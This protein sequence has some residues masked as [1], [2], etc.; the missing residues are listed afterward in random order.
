MPST[1]KPVRPPA[2]KTPDKG[3]GSGNYG[4]ELDLSLMKNQLEAAKRAEA[5]AN[6]AY[7]DLL[8][9]H[10]ESQRQLKDVNKRIIEAQMAQK[11]LD[12]SPAEEFSK[13]QRKTLRSM[14]LGMSNRQSFGFAGLTVLLGLVAII[15]RVE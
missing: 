6:Q 7:K 1:P 11:K 14:G 8:K 12:S 2:G 15:G 4:S 5:R 13:L 10:K 3:P 9:E